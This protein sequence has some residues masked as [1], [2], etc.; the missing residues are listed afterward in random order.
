MV[1]AVW[2]TD[3]AWGDCFALPVSSCFSGDAGAAGGDFST[4]AGVTGDSVATAASS[5]LISK[6]G[7]LSKEPGGRPDF[8]RAGFPLA[9]GDLV[10]LA[11]L[12][13]FFAGSVV[14]FRFFAVPDLLT[15][16]LFIAF[17]FAFAFAF[18]FV[19][20]FADLDFAVFRF[21]LLVAIPYPFCGPIVSGRLSP[22]PAQ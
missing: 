15:A 21:R 4:A 6:S 3:L 13:F 20:A 16:A 17:A 10:D 18:D 8:S 9:E 22:F 14:F 19:F 2:W 1:F 11:F 7:R 12:D 5:T